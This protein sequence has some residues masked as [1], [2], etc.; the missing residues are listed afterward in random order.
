MK[1]GVT[2]HTFANHEV[3]KRELLK[4]F[5]ETVFN[6][7][8]ARPS[9]EDIVRL[10]RDCEGAIV[11]LEKINEDVLKFCPGLKILSKYGVGLD[12]I[13]LEACERH[14]VAIGWAPGVNR[15]AVA[16]L[17]LG[18]M[19]AL[20][21]NIVG[22]CSD[23]KN[24]EWRKYGGIELSGKVVGVI[25]VG[26]IGREVVRLLKPFNCTVLCNDILD[27]GDYYSANGVQP[28]SKDRIYAE[29][30]IIT[31]HT[32]LTGLTK[33][34]ICREVLLKMKKTAF[35]V[36]TARGGIISKADL[37]WA[38]SENII[39]GAA[40][41]VYPEEPETDMDFLRLPNL[42]CTPHRAGSSAEAVLSMGLC[43]IDHL[44]KY[45]KLPQ[46][47]PEDKQ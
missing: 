8:K 36:N 41:D 39:S 5:P 16:E 44:R 10:L 12:N 27:L 11:G 43:A 45:F 19:L 42:V 28:A 22:G 34:L 29:A 26:N 14:G 4:S 20:L 1:I 24:G 31:L 2:A 13:D 33:D 9:R 32:P 38:L 46:A 23:L 21:R 47:L 18:F 6:D 17:T 30:D 35:I 25:G 3:L 40:V 15:L 7:A 37:K